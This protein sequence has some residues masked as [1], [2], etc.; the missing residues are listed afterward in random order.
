MFSI[1]LFIPLRW[2]ETTPLCVVKLALG[3]E[4]PG[5]GLTRA[6]YFLIH[7]QFLS[8]LKMNAAVY[9][10]ALLFFLW[11]VS[12]SFRLF[13]GRYPMWSSKRGNQMIS[14]SFLVLLFLQWMLKL[15]PRLTATLSL[16]NSGVTF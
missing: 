1:A 4:C 8:A 14:S 12:H 7:L 6:F 9:P 3:F 5:C 10:L 13:W 16:V 15:L 11:G 2:I